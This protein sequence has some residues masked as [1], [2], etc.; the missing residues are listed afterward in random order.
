M[1]SIAIPRHP[2]EGRGPVQEGVFREVLEHSSR[3]GLQGGGRA[4]ESLGI[5]DDNWG[6]GC[7]MT[8]KD[9]GKIYLWKI[10]LKSI[11]NVFENLSKI[12]RKS[13]EHLSI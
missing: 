1:P 4:F 6:D 9:R 5:R 12:Y 10:D 11:W 8:W 13:I 3:S 2:W 7:M